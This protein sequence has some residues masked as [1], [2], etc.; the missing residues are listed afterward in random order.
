V[1]IAQ[2]WYSIKEVAYYYT[3]IKCIR[4]NMMNQNL[5]YK[6][7]LKMKKKS[8]YKIKVKNITPKICPL[9]SPEKQKDIIGKP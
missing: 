3:C 7:I 9:L 8:E 5:K 2:E 4:I 1:N 6:N